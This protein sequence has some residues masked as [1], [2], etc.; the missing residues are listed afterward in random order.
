MKKR[1]LAVK[2]D[3]GLVLGRAFEYALRRMMDRHDKYSETP[4]TPASRRLLENEGLNSLWLALDDEG[5]KW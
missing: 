5:I 4:L 2:K 1:K 3:T